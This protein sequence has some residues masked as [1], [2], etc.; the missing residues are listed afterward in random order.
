MEKTDKRPKF[1]KGQKV[2]CIDESSSGRLKVNKVYTVKWES[3]GWITLKEMDK[4]TRG[5]QFPK[6]CFIPIRPL[7][8][9]RKYTRQEWW[10]MAYNRIEQYYRCHPKEAVKEVMRKCE[11]V[12]VDLS[13]KEIKRLALKGLK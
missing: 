11:S 9:W 13:T 7:R 6:R 10:Q 2:I 4:W 8:R 5:W 12:Y 1:K 3:H